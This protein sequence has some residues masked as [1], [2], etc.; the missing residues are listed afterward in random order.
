MAETMRAWCCAAPGPVETTI[1]LVEDAAKPS[2]PLQNGEILVEV[3]YAGLNPAD[4]KPLELGITSRALASFPKTPGM[5]LSGRVVGVAPDVKDTKPGDLVAARM[6]H[7]KKEGALSQFAVVPR[8]GYATIPR[9]IDLEQ[10]AGIGTAAQAAYQS[11]APYVK[12]GDKVFINGASGGVGT[13]DIQIAKA[14]GCHVTVSCSTA[15]VDLCKELGAD[16]IIDYKTTD[17]TAELS[18]AGQVYKLA[19]DNVSY[20]PPDLYTKS[21]K[22]LLPDGNFIS[23]GGAVS[24]S[25]AKTITRNLL[26]PSF[27]GGGKRK[28]SVF[29]VKNSRDDLEQIVKWMVDGKVKTVIDSVFDFEDTVKAFEHLKMGSS[30]GKV[31]VRLA[32]TK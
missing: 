13:F 6:H 11:I 25:S 19:V 29:L 22:F 17:V 10:A 16:E 8:D 23:I 31:V 4:H 32:G 15:K 18:K 14:L 1:K 20:S 3:A 26:L 5:D 28:F 21:H 27:L 2:K 7:D 30:T 9:E 24:F 12:A